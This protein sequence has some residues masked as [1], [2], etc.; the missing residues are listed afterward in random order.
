[1]KMK[2]I[3]V[4]SLIISV[5]A[6]S[7]KCELTISDKQTQRV[8]KYTLD[9]QKKLQPKF[10][11]TEF[12]CAVSAKDINSQK[13]HKTTLLTLACVIHNTK[14]VAMTTATISKDHGFPG[15]LT[16]RDKKGKEANYILAC[17]L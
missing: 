4:L 7:Q 9:L 14:I 16:L 17:T 12:D 6:F 15:T 10:K 11:P 1:M 8:K 13:S 2:F 5:K 3:I